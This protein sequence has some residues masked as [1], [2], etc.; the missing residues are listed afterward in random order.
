[1]LKTA[2]DVTALQNQ[3]REL[4]AQAQNLGEALAKMGPF[5]NPAPLTG[6]DRVG[7]RVHQ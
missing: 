6:L 1:M 3:R 7:D 4:K 5:H 2:S